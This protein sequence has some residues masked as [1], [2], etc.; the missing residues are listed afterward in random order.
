MALKKMLYVWPRSHNQQ[1]LAQEY[2]MRMSSKTR[3]RINTKNRDP[4]VSVIS[5]KNPH[6]CEPQIWVENFWVRKHLDVKNT[7]RNSLS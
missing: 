7:E 2:P 5:L 1:F 6:F 4:K 3:M